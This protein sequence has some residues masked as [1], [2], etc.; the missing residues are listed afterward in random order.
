[1]TSQRKIEANRRKA[2]KSSGPKTAEGKKRVRLNALKHGL[3][4]T[5]IV[6][7]HEDDE[8]YQERLDGWTRELNPR[9]DVGQY[10]T[11]QAVRLSWQLDRADR[12]ERARLAERVNRLSRKRE[13]ARNRN[14]ENL[15]CSLMSPRT[16]QSTVRKLPTT[17]ETEPWQRPSS[18]GRP[19]IPRP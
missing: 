9:G 4:A 1:M 13:R 8:A 3:T 12:H 14:V 7:P 6:L 15:M 11:A 2:Q 5:T 18:P 17:G 19:T 16:G 10:L